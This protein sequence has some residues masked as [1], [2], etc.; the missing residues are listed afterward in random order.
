MTIAIFAEVSENAC[1][2]DRNLYDNE[3]MHLVLSQSSH[4]IDISAK[5]DTFCSVVSLRQLMY[6]FYFASAIVAGVSSHSCAHI[7]DFGA[8]AVHVQVV[9]M[10]TRVSC[11][12]HSVVLVIFHL[13]VA[14]L[15]SDIRYYSAT[16]PVRVVLLLSLTLD[17]DMSVLVLGELMS[18]LMI[19]SLLCR[20]MWYVCSVQSLGGIF[21][22]LSTCSDSY[23]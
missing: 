4:R 8:F 18:D 6:L 11:V 23:R 3:Y 14:H 20:D 2:D 10:W 19:A 15:L 9:L 16:V 5:T 1:I 21:W 12:V 13:V 7:A 17:G 22:A